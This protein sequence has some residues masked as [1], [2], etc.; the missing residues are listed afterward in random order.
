MSSELIISSV[1]VLLLILISAFFSGSETALTAVSRALI[2][3]LSSEG[4]RRARIVERLT[5]D[6]ER[7]IGGVLLGNNLVNILASAIATS[8]FIDIFGNAGVAYATLAMTALVL[9][10]AEVLPKTYAISSP[11]RTALSVG[12]FLTVIIALLSPV[13]KTVQQIVR[14][15]LHIFGIDIDAEREV[16]S[17]HE[18][19]RGALDLQVQEGGMIK[20]ERDMLGG[21]LDLTQV[22][23]DEVMVH[24]Q[25][26]VMID[27]DQTQ[28]R[29]VEQILASPFT[30]IP[31]YRGDTENIIGILHAKD[32]LRAISKPGVKVE[33]LDFEALASEPWFVPETT[34]LREQLNAFRRRRAHFAL[35]VDEYG[36]LMGLVTLEDIIEEIVGDISDEHD[37]LAR[38]IRPQRDGSVVVEGTVTIRDL[39]RQF[40]WNLSDEWATTIAGYVIHEAR[41]IPDVG[42]VFSF[43]GFRF[44]ILRRHRNQVTLLRI[45]RTEQPASQ[46]S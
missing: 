13:V 42:Q 7:L 8:V 43:S 40:D 29:I 39:N 33:D 10:F 36:A 18:Q 22:E 25:N 46:E 23:V 35:V 16:L 38:G 3:R 9:V 24:R 27:A 2:H 15:M 5:G 31:L 19:L 12:P 20:H 1:S 6:R 32:V 30:R 28:Q 4:D 26:M 45:K 41:A 44:E 34:T 11:D 21:I 17:A 37:P 14:M